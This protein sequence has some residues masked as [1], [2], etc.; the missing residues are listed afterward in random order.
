MVAVSSGIKLHPECIYITEILFVPWWAD[1]VLSYSSFL[2]H[3]STVAS[4]VGISFKFIL[5]NFWPS[6]VCQRM[7]GNHSQ[8]V[9]MVLGLAMCKLSLVYLMVCLLAAQTFDYMEI[10]SGEGW[11]TRTM[12]SSG[13]ATASF[14]ILLGDPKPNKQDCMDLTTDSGFWFPGWQ[15]CG[16]QLF[17]Y[18]QLSPLKSPFIF[19]NCMRIAIDQPSIYQESILCVYLVPFAVVKFKGL[20]DHQIQDINKFRFDIAPSVPMGCHRLGPATESL[21]FVHLEPEVRPE[22]MSDWVTVLFLRSNQCCN[23][24]SHTME[25]SG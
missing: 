19:G 23:T 3:V 14:D 24:C 9:R 7:H 5:Q 4:M 21:P 10:F 6:C 25:P 2:K 8:S 11:V 17:S 1:R 13:M 16:L 22:S 20:I 12:G 15:V 18:L